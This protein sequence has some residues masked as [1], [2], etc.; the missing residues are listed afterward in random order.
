M[1]VRVVGVMVLL[2]ITIICMIMRLVVRLLV[3]RSLVGVLGGALG[4]VLLALVVLCT[5]VQAVFCAAGKAD[6]VSCLLWG[7]GLSSLQLAWVVGQCLQHG[8][9]I[10]IYITHCQ[11][12]I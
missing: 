6:G 7:C 12:V 8:N 11:G 4:K 10:H 2:S 3:G 5:P 9:G 1:R